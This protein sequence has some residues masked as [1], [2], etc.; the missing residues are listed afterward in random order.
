MPR[1]STGIVFQKVILVM[2]ICNVLSQNSDANDLKPRDCKWSA[3]VDHGCS[4]TCGEHVMRTKKRMKLQEAGNGGRNCRGATRRIMP[5]NFPE[6]ENLRIPDDFEYPDDIGIF[7]SQNILN[8]II[9]IV[10][11][12]R[13]F[14]YNHPSIHFRERVEHRKSLLLCF[15]S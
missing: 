10:H 15:Y 6:C 12:K 13:F 14:D 9:K 3:W 5:C 11:T 7:K 4:A 8:L 1:A 2:T